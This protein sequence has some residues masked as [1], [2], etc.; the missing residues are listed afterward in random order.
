MS[1]ES[2][3]EVLN[4]A[5]F[6]AV[7]AAVEAYREN[8]SGMPNVLVR[9]LSAVHSNTV[10][11]DLPEPVQKVLREATDQTF[12]KLMQAGYSVVPKTEVMSH[13]PDRGKRAR[14]K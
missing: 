5:I 9:D 3:K 1:R 4:A 8:A 14:S 11:T 12:R 10:F 7:C 13:R 6:S 2:A